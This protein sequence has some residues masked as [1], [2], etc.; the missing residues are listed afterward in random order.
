MELNYLRLDCPVKVFSLDNRCGK[1]ALVKDIARW[2]A[3]ESIKQ[4]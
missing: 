1:Y 2:L 4:N 3:N